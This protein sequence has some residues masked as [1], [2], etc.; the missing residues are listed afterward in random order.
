MS[1]WD[2]QDK[3]GYIYCLNNNTG[4]INLD[5]VFGTIIYDIAKTSK[6]KTY[7]EIGTWNGLGS[8]KCFIE[9]FK[10]RTDDFIFYSLE[11]N[12]EKS[13][14][15][16]NMYKNINNVNILNEV[17]FNETPSDLYE[18]FPELKN[19]N[20]YQQWHDIDIMNMRNCNLF[21]NRTNLPEIFDVV[22]LDGG[23]FTTYHEFKKIENKCKLLLL[24]DTNTNKCNRIVC[25]IKQNSDKWKII[26]EN[27]LERNGFLVCERI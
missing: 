7:L 15:A 17:L 1:I 18:T 2:I 8:T 25:E 6:Y 26:I 9:G 24:D 3:Q 21:F 13:Y 4:Q 19:N 5:T 16:K 20:T 12:P 23:E 11:C 10:S 22:L 14:I 27:K